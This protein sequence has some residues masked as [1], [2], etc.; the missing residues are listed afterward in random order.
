MAG[1]FLHIIILTGISIALYYSISKT[2]L[3]NSLLLLTS[4]L[5]YYML[6]GEKIAILGIIIITSFFTAKLLHT[7]HYKKYILFSGIAINVLLL[8]SH[9]YMLNI[10]P[11]HKPSL[12]IGLSF[13][14]FQSISYIIDVY[15][16]KDGT[17]YSF[18]ETA[19]FIAFFPKLL[20]GPLE[21]IDSFIHELRKIHS[22]NGK[23]TFTAFKIIT[24][25]LTVKFVLAD[26]IGVSVDG[27]LLDYNSLSAINILI[28][29]ALFSFQIFFDFYA[30]S[31]LAIG[32]AQLYGIKLSYNFNNPYFSTSFYDFWKRWN[33]TLTSWFRDYIYI[34]LGGNRVS[35]SRWTA[36][37]M[38]VF[39]ISGIWHGATFN[40]ILWGFLH[41][42]FYVIERTVYKRLPFYY[43]QNSP[44]I[45]LYSC[46]V[47][48]FLSL[49]WLLFK[50]DN[51]LLLT[52]LFGRLL[53]A[54]SWDI[55][56]GMTLWF[57][58]TTSF[59]FI[60]RK[61]RLPEKYIF[62]TKNSLAFIGKEICL[63]NAMVILLFL[64]SASG[65]SS[66]IYFK[67]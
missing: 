42:L 35:T 30:Y 16:K 52:T 45:F 44:L 46:I 50:I 54:W 10:Y 20:A 51:H 63:I 65:N 33:I 59:I 57:I 32:I 5:F 62:Q 47:F 56:L 7:T 23:R 4:L 64:F 19:T 22:Y 26:Q 55:N 40:F 21:R 49:L 24:Y 3:R 60:L 67:F 8:L 41:G 36:N 12:P 39:I 37:V 17:T 58:S 43:R 18:V 27:S 48:I 15:R 28:T 2:T 25:A 11:F 1:T 31:I 13:Y 66:F 9:K 6:E 29:A 14:T 34:P 61:Y 38:I 53:S